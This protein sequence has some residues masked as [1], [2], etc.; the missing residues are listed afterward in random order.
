MDLL[1]DFEFN[2]I[3]IKSNVNDAQIAYNLNKHLGV[4]FE[5]ENEDLDVYYKD[6][7][8]AVYFPKF[9]YQDEEKDETWFL[10]KNSATTE[11]KVE[12]DQGDLFSNNEESSIITKYILFDKKEFDYLLKIDFIENQK[13]IDEIIKTIYNIPITTT[14]YLF[15]IKKLR[16][17]QNIIF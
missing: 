6:L 15:N 4:F 9:K 2:L 7:K 5:R 8:K 3:G 1:I 12:K 11:I 14:A 16:S 10:I 17:K 13:R